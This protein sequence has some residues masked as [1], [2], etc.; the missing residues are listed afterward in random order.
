MNSYN[1]STYRKTNEKEMNA[2]PN[3][4]KG[5]NSEHPQNNTKKKRILLLV[6]AV[7]AII[8]IIG[9][10]VYFT[11]P[12]NK[13]I[14][15]I[16]NTNK[17]DN[18]VTYVLSKEEALEAF[19]PNFKVVTKTNNL[20]QI[21]MK[22]NLKHTSISNGVESITLSVFTKAK[23]D[24]YTLN[25]SLAIEDNKEFYSNRYC[26]VITINSMCTVFSSSNS[27]CELEQYLDLTI[28]S[29]NL[30][31]ID[32][33]NIEKIKDAILP[34][35]IIEHTDTN[36]IISVTCPETL[37]YN[38]KE[39]II[40]SFQSIKPETIKGIVNDSSLAGTSITQKDNRKYIDSFDKACDD[41]DG[42]PTLNETC[43]AIKNIVTDLD[44]N[45]KVSLL[46]NE[47]R[48]FLISIKYIL[49]SF[50]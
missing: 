4:E 41:Y 30:R 39:D 2:I 46:F 6:F 45:T 38:L 19:K 14:P 13:K 7:I 48:I 18:T 9:V 8:I 1:V 37:S 43:E 22:T 32:E 34:I 29:K 24:I 12:S 16:E 40:S 31:A 50:K 28:K 3:Q 27:D 44:G 17:T 11:I 49:F 10:I 36:I 15:I 35:C 20:N 33:E 26:T 5:N 21:L 25:E 23:L 42:D 47:L